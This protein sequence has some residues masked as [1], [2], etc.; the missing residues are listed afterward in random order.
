MPG[1]FTA[2]LI[3]FL[4]RLKRNNNRDWFL[5]HQDEFE[6]CVRQPA[7]R[8]ISDFASPLYEIAPHLN[9]DPRPSRGSM[10]R[11]Y[12]DVRCNVCCCASTITLGLPDYHSRCPVFHGMIS[13]DCPEQLFESVT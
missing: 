2:E 3:R 7:F 8:F 9:A 13:I 1:Y 12:R 5:A 10:F 11:I 6:T 4:A